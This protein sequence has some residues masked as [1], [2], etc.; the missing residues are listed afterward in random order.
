MV[1]FHTM[2]ACVAGES[3]GSRG[4]SPRTP[5]TMFFRPL[6]LEGSD[7]RL[8]VSIL[9]LLAGIAGTAFCEAP[10]DMD[11]AHAKWAWHPDAGAKSVCFRKALNYSQP[12]EGMEILI[13]A[14]DS[15]ELRVNGRVVGSGADWKTPQRYQ[16]ARPI[17]RESSMVAVKCANSDGAAG[18]ICKVIVHL[19]DGTD[20]TIVSDASWRCS[21]K[22]ATDWD[23]IHAD[24][25]VDAW[26]AARAVGEYPCQPWGQVI[27]EKWESLQARLIAR[28]AAIDQA[29][30][31]APP[32]APAYS[33]FKGKYLRPEYAAAYKSF[34]R[35]NGKT[36]LLETNGR[37]LRPFFTIYV[38]PK[39]GGASVLTIPDFDYDLVEQDF[40]RMKQSG[41]NVYPRFWNWSELLNADGSWQ[42]VKHQP[43]GRSLPYFRYVYQVYDYFL[44]RAQAHGLYVNIEP[45]YYWGLHPDIVPPQYRDKIV[46]YGELWDAAKDAY[47]KI[48]NYYS[49]RTVI[50]SAMVG[51]EDLEFG[52]CLDE[53]EMQDRFRQ[54]LKKQYGTIT[55]LQRT[56]TSGYDY[57]DHSL[58][59]ERSI[60]DKQVIWPAYQLTK[61]AFDSL[62]SFDD[63]KLPVY[64]HY[65]SANNTGAALNDMPTYQ[66]NLLRDPMWIDF[67]EMKQQILISRLN[68]LADAFHAA[69]PNHI[70]Y[71]CNPYD[72][73]PAWHFMHCFDRA[74]LRWDVIGVGQHDSGFEPWQVPKWA[75]CREY[76][77]NVAAYGPYLDAAGAYPKGIACGEG[78]GGKTREGIA[79][80]YP[81]WLTD[82]IGGGG[83]FFQSYDWNAISGRTSENPTAYDS[84]TLDTLGRF[85]SAVQSAPFGLK[86]D[87]E[88]LILRNKQAAYGMSAGYDFG[89]EL[90]LASLLYQFHVPFDIL[91]D[92]DVTLGT[93]EQGKVNLAGYRFIFVP[94]QN[95]LLS[96]RT[97]QLLQDWISDSRFAG[98]RGLCFGL[99]Q[100]QDAYFNPI[101]PTSV[102]PAF[103]QLIGATGYTKRLP[104]SGKVQMYFH[105]PLGGEARGDSMT[106]ELPA[107]GELGCFEKLP[108]RLES[109]L[110]IGESGPTVVARNTVNKNPIYTC[111]FY[112][113]LAYNPVWGMAKE[114]EPYNA[115]SPLYGGMLSSVGIEPEFTAADNLGIYFSDDLAT[116]LVKERYGKPTDVTLS[117]KRADGTVYGGTTTTLSPAGVTTVK[118]PHLDAYGTMVLRRAVGIKLAGGSEIGWTCQVAPDGTVDLVISGKGRVFGSYDLRPKTTYSAH[119]DGQLAM[120]F[121]TDPTGIHKMPL[122]VPSKKP[123][124]L[125]LRPGKR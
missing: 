1:T 42:E 110:S 66:E 114:Q 121:T 111:G 71:Y 105:T 14:D 62:K 93:F 119:V 95:Q 25:A 84:T 36:G 10:S 3:L 6:V 58:W 122:D 118:A 40:A 12:V 87:V 97:W 43:K 101:Q 78:M 35:L 30:A 24:P 86:R 44:D 21:D 17:A 89:N 29:V 123:L 63:V 79:R 41:I 59:Q 60:D 106:I 68:E 64:D 69:D 115:L 18:M 102:H 109:I 112:L 81:W 54:F 47:S 27:K 15:F 125:V 9:L 49:K 52:Q 28:R 116:A 75:T 19:H 98:K 20:D 11:F 45:S 117:Y 124:H 72:N 108:S 38:Q 51:E 8:A 34:V 70:M 107:E 94:A 65:R 92:S 31:K 37:V 53:P 77:Q 48:L 103:E 57:S 82:L 99:Y 26:P 13:T 85:L 39:P 90:Y 67:M 16:V 61:G 33:E 2:A 83:A 76:V 96:S 104:T 32:S 7:L 22:E 73:N 91:P 4:T 100:D 5:Q 113:G 56:W 120:V 74:R 46:L 50:I 80:Y 88:V 23:T 55:N